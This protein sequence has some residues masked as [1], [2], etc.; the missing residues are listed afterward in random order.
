MTIGVMIMY[1]SAELLTLDS[2][3]LPVPLVK[4]ASFTGFRDG[5]LY[6]DFGLWLVSL[7]IVYEI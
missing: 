5:D 1:R 7:R 4:M 2:E 3:L 6:I